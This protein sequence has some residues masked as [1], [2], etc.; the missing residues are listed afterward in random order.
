MLITK[1]ITR[2][3]NIPARNK[4]ILHLQEMIGLYL[5]LPGP[6]YS[7]RFFVPLLTFLSLLYGIAGLIG[8]LLDL[9]FIASFS[10]LVFFISLFILSL[11]LN[12]LTFLLLSRRFLKQDSLPLLSD[13]TSKQIHI[14]VVRIIGLIACPLLLPIMAL[15]QVSK[16]SR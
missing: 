3:S 12:C 13:Y 6:G 9:V 14:T 15:L 8:V 7:D 4:Q 16:G 2:M 5:A 1:G 10:L 11:A